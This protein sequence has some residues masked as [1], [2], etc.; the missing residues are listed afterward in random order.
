MTFHPT[1]KA[2]I[3]TLLLL[4]GFQT[5]AF[6]QKAPRF[7]KTPVGDSGASVYLP[8]L[9]VDQTVSYSPDSSKV[10]TMEAIDTSQGASYRFGVIVVNLNGVDLK[11]MEEEMLTQ[12]M[13]Y[14]KDMFGVK[15]S[16]GYGKGHTLDTHPTAKGV[17][18]YW[19]DAEETHWVVKGWAAESTLFVMFI[20]GPEDYPNVNVA[21]LYL[22]G[23]RFAGD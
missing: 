1:F 6:A 21:Q 7:T 10:Y 8:G 20:Y 13:D 3:I 9:P 4:A 17:L 23:A 16:A 18:D 12:Y 15:Q 22:N 5:A 19:L 2:C 14:L 11:D